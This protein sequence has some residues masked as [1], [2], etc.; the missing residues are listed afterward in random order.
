[1]LVPH[2]PLD[3]ALL[4]LP[5]SEDS[6]DSSESSFPGLEDMKRVTRHATYGFGPQHGPMF[7][8]SS[9]S[10]HDSALDG[11]LDDN[12]VALTESDDP[13]DGYQPSPDGWSPT[14]PLEGENGSQPPRTPTRSRSQSPYPTSPNYRQN[15]QN[16]P[17]PSEAENI[18]R[19]VEDA[20]ADD[21]DDHRDDPCIDIRRHRKTLSGELMRLRWY[22][23]IAC[24]DRDYHQRRQSTLEIGARGDGY[25]IRWLRAQNDRLDQQARRDRDENDTLTA[26]HDTRQDELDGLQGEL[27]GRDRRISDL[28]EENIALRQLLDDSEDFAAQTQ[29][30]LLD[31]LRGERDLA[32]RELALS[33]E[34]VEH[35]QNE[36]RASIR[37]WRTRYNALA[38]K[39]DERLGTAGNERDA[40][41]QELRDSQAQTNAWRQQYHVLAGGR[42]KE[43]A[44]LQERIADLR[45]QNVD[46]QNAA[47]GDAPPPATLPEERPEND[48]SHVHQVNNDLRAERD[49]LAQQLA[50]SRRNMMLQWRH[51]DRA[52]A[53]LRERLANRVQPTGNNTDPRQNEIDRLQQLLTDTRNDREVVH[54]EFRR[55]R[56]EVEVLRAQQTAAANAVADRSSASP[57]PRR[58]SRSRTFRPSPPPVAGTYTD[59]TA[60]GMHQ[61]PPA[62]PPAAP[63][64]APAPA[65]QAPPARSARPGRMNT[66]AQAA[67]RQR[68]LPP[69][70][71]SPDTERRRAARRAAPSP[72]PQRAPANPARPTGVSERGGKKTRGRK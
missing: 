20:I 59:F 48:N 36:W 21:P 28:E 24:E 29:Q 13:E 30:G 17:T 44:R 34:T 22:L 1:V 25:L 52:N 11:N 55:I 27:E 19:I 41:R 23:R 68:S 66:R 31:D 7:P 46:L 6:E 51:F 4:A 65:A 40:A 45:R 32:R 2:G 67:A 47:R 8:E 43:N 61:N 50:D 38:A 62:N 53:Q 14:S 60:P 15:P 33:R 56:Q 9:A 71:Y 12:L 42:D 54:R 63:P 18:D 37:Q 16:T 26:L 39:R 10:R 58:R 69:A 35:E 49:H 3:A 57:A 70:L 5:G 64:A 72:Q